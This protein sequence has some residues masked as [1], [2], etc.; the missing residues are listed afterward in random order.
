MDKLFVNGKIWVQKGRWAEALAVRDNRVLAVGSREDVTVKLSKSYKT[1]DMEGGMLMPGFHDGHLHLLMGGFSLLQLSLEGITE[2]NRALALIQEKAQEVEKKNGGKDQ[3]VIG[4]GFDENRVQLRKADLDKLCPKIPVLIRTRDLHS[5]IVNEVALKLAGI[6]SETPY[7]PTGRIERDEQGQP[8]GFLRE[9]AVKMV[10]SIIPLPDETIS[11][12]AMNKAQEQAFRYGITSVS[13]SIRVKNLSTYQDFH[14][15]GFRKIRINGWRVIEEWQLK[16]VPPNPVVDL[17]FQVR[18]LKGFVDGAMGSDTAWL[19]EDFSHRPGYRGI[20]CVEEP[21]LVGVMRQAEKLGYRMA[22]HAIGDRANRVALNAYEQTQVRPDRRHRIEHA[23]LLTPTDIPRFSK[24]GIIASM[25][26]I[27]C[28]D[29]MAWKIRKVGLERVKSAY[30]WR[31]L[32][33]S[34]AK[35]VFGTDWPVADLNP[36]QGLRAAVTRRDADGMPKEGWNAAQAVTLEEAL[37]IYTRGGAYG[38]GWEK[39]VGT[40]MPGMR[41]DMIWLDKNLLEIDPLEYVKVKVKKTWVDGEEVF[42]R[43]VEDA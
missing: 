37:D 10:D 25:Q 40:L 16:G 34:G 39:E 3:W 12:E 29:D 42:L 1:I 17:G 43:S 33:D 8:T 5:A 4:I 18:T 21:E 36:M 31:S 24:L 11:L 38:A 20:G 23:Q 35:L 30:A 19:L 26:P 14:K 7:P 15:K 32:L 41:A 13:D 22:L 6:T 2:R 9:E 27:H 28:T